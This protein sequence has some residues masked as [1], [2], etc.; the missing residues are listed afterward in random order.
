MT[1]DRF[2]VS[3]ILKCYKNQEKISCVSVYD[4]T[5]AMLADRAGVDLLLVG[6]S[7][8]MTMSIFKII[9]FRMWRQGVFGKYLRSIL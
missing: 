9:T 2:T 3:D 7:L 8:G 1:T 6:D 4:S 5:M